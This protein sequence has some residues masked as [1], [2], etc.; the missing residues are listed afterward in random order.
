M[1]ACVLLCVLFLNLTSTK[2]ETR[3]KLTGQ[4][5][6]GRGPVAEVKEK[7]GQDNRESLAGVVPSGRGGLRGHHLRQP[8]QAGGGGDPFPPL[9]AVVAEVA[10]HAADLDGR[11]RGAD[12]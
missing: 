7:S 2:Q 10:E 9:G 8:V 11:G 1:Q 3:N 5:C 12:G 4:L 6:G